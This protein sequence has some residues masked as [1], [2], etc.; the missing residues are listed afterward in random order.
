M[1]ESFK[2][3]REHDVCLQALEMSGLRLKEQLDKNKLLTGVAIYLF[4]ISGDTGNNDDATNVTV[5]ST[6][7]TG[8]T[9]IRYI[10]H[11]MKNQIARLP[12]SQQPSV[13]ELLTAMGYLKEA[14]NLIIYSMGLGAMIGYFVLLALVLVRNLLTF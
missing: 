4:T 9:E 13:S 7:V 1:T 6:H 5:I 11:D 8:V 3:K 2:L 10:V 12:P 14:R